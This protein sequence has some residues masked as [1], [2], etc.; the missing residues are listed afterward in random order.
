MSVPKR[1]KT[2]SERDKRRSHIFIKFPHFSLCP[3][4]GKEVLDHTVCSSCGYYKG[5]E[6]INVLEKLTKK[7]RKAREK[8]MAQK[9]KEE[10]KEEKPLS[11]AELSKKPLT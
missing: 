7:E 9:T 5:R 8:E 3:K 11:A 6:V 10:G 4:C 2:K 1:H